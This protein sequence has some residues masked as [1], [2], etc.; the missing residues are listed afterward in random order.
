MELNSSNL[1]SEPDPP[2]SSK[3]SGETPAFT[4]PEEFIISQ[5]PDEILATLQT[6]LLLQLELGIDKESVFKTLPK[7][8]DA[9]NR[10]RQTNVDTELGS[11]NL[12]CSVH[13]GRLLQIIQ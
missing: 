5:I 7:K 9:Q 2:Q 3:P 8:V 6:A 10:D 12:L 11:K 1:F 13:V 4:V